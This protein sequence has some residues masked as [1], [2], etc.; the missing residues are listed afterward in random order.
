M[1][2]PPPLPDRSS[3]GLDANIAAALAYLGWFATGIVFLVIEKD[4]RFV[5][6]HAL[7]STFFFLPVAVAQMVLWSIPFVGWLLA[8]PIWIGS[9]IAW[10]VLMLKAYQGERYKLPVVGDLAEQQVR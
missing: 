1:S 6:F 2:L 3:T 9:L 8:F 4:S 5:K 10:L 7:Q